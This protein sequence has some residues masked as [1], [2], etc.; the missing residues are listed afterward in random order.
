MSEPILMRRGF[1]G[2]GVEYQLKDGKIADWWF[3][4]PITAEQTTLATARAIA[5]KTGWNDAV[6][7]A[8]ES[9]AQP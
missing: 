3:T 9:P 1:Q 8:K 4:S 5:Y 6:A 7:D 2:V